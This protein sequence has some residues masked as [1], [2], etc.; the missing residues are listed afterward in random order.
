MAPCKL[1]NDQEKKNEDDGRLAFDF[2]PDELIQSAS[3]QGCSSCIVILEGLRKSATEGWNFDHDVRRVYARCRGMHNQKP[4]TLSLEVYFKNDRP[5]LEL[6]FFSLGT[7]AWKAILP[8]TSI[9]GHPLSQKAL[10]WTSSLLKTCVEQHVVCQNPKI[11]QL[12]KRVLAIVPTGESGVNV[13]LVEDQ[14]E[15]APY[16]AL[17][18][19]WGMHRTCVTTLETLEGHK[20]GI[21]W[22][23]IPKTFQDAILFA[24]RLNIRYIWVDSLCII[25]DD[26]SDWEVESSKMADIYQHSYLTLAATA[27]PSD[28]QGCYPEY[29]GGTDMSPVFIPLAFTKSCP[30]AVRKPLGHWDTVLSNHLIH[31]YP[32]LSRGWAFQERLLSPRTLHF[33]GSE[34]VWECREAS[35]CE[36][37]NLDGYTSPGGEY[38]QVL[39]RSEGQHRSNSVNV[40]P[41]FINPMDLVVKARENELSMYAPGYE[42]AKLYNQVLERLKS[43][44]VLQQR[45]ETVIQLLRMEKE[46]SE[47]SQQW[48][49][50]VE[51]YSALQITKPTDRLPAFSG[52]CKRIKHLRGDYMAG[53]WV[54]SVWLDLLWRVNVLQPEMGNTK[55]S[56]HRRPS[57]S[58]VSVRG[59]VRYWDDIKCLSLGPLSCYPD[60]DPN[61]LALN[62]RELRRRPLDFDYDVQLAGKN[63]FGEVASAVLR[64]KSYS[65]AAVLRPTFDNLAPG[66][67]NAHNP[68]KYNIEVGGHEVSFFADYALTLEGPYA[69]RGGEMVTLLLIHP[70][71]ALVLTPSSRSQER[72]QTLERGL[73]SRLKKLRNKFR[74][75][76]LAEKSLKNGL[77]ERIGIVRVSDTLLDLYQVDWMDGAEV[78]EFYIV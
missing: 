48:R 52:L 78:S 11:P 27:S 5:K 32:L 9:S 61:K 18:H 22:Y 50:L 39:A 34:L 31:D 44:E 57:W 2:T 20:R 40:F 38:H 62:V 41:D 71:I 47:L 28:S 49:K 13:H 8:R 16:A 66:A 65:R 54:D 25:Q 70:Q 43:E 68:F 53:L 73:K 33:C 74:N 64:I 75:S 45:Y 67:S 72:S 29:H 4:T 17:S 3:R 6:E 42:Y 19:C 51:Q 76:D 63:S 10:A 60:E 36:C 30:V 58:W 24:L 7:E 46:P 14:M 59:P 15:Y 12:P 69:S 56:Q 37:G 23:S 1:C 77:W 55:R 35:T 26:P 21:Q